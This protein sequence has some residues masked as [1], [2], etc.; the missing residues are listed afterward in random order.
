MQ[1]HLTPSFHS[2]TTHCWPPAYWTHW[3]RHA[4]LSEVSHTFR[5]EILVNKGIKQMRKASLH[6]L[7]ILMRNY[8][9]HI[10]KASLQPL[11]I[12]K[13][14]CNHCSHFNASLIT[15]YFTALQLRHIWMYHYSHRIFSCI[16]A[17]TLYFNAYLQ[18]LHSLMHHY[19]HFLFLCIF[20]AT[21]YLNA[22]L[23][24]LH[25]FE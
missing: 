16:V 6:P 20:A 2:S 15:A 17:T 11:H 7:H 24:P 13:H 5:V 14:H 9:R 19:S 12:L 21:A 4:T 22:P 18:P 25:I 10:C 1:T 23:Q 8:S 3:R